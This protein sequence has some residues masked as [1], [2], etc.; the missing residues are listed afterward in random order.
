M[1][2]HGAMQD[3]EGQ[4]LSHPT[5]LLHPE[6]ASLLS[7]SAAA[8]SEQA[9]LCWLCPCLSVLAVSGSARRWRFP[10]THACTHGAAMADIAAWCC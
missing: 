5:L 6:F 10:C 9:C 3:V 4:V 8:W 7:G 1:G 2:A